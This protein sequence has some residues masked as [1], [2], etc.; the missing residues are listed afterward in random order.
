MVHASGPADATQARQVARQASVDEPANLARLAPAAYRATP[1]HGP[2]ANGCAQMEANGSQ[3]EPME[4]YGRTQSG[5]SRHSHTGRKAKQQLMM[6]HNSP[7]R[8]ESTRF[9]LPGV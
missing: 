6:W 4:G 5:A 2:E 8:C 9:A 7:Q 1:C 3:W